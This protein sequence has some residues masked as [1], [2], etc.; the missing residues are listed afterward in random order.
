MP[1]TPTAGTTRYYYD[2]VNEIVEDN[3]SGTRQRYYVHGVSYIDERLMMYSDSL[4]RPFYYVV[5]RMNNVRMLIDR[6]GAIVER[7]ALDTTGD[8]VATLRGQT[9]G[10]CCRVKGMTYDAYG[11]PRIR[12]SCGRGDMNDNTWMDS[13]DTSRF[14]AAKNGSIWDPRA[15]LDAERARGGSVKGDVDSADQTPDDAFA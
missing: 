6:A 9:P 4:S 8:D 12:E 7:P 13:T 11:R 10:V 2:G 1:T 14:T 15:D 3:Q 5:D